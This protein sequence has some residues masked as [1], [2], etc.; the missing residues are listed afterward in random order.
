MFRAD[1]AEAS[2]IKVRDRQGPHSQGAP[3]LAGNAS[4]IEKYLSHTGSEGHLAH[5]PEQ[6]EVGNKTSLG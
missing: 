6:Q 3:G 4:H 1:A 2:R 5:E